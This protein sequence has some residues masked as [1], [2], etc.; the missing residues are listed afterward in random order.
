[1]YHLY[2][3]A[4]VVSPILVSMLAGLI[5]ACMG[6]SINEGGTDACVRLGIPFGAILNPL[7]SLF[8]FSII[9]VILGVIATVLLIIAAIHDTIY[10]NNQ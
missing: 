10:Y 2:I 6:C 3:I 1:L 4:F 8:W 9:T 7:G 5:G